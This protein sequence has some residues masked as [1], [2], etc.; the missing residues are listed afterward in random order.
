MNLP[1]TLTRGPCRHTHHP[2]HTMHF[3]SVLQMAAQQRTRVPHAPLCVMHSHTYTHP[4][5]TVLSACVA[6]VSQMAAQQVTRVPP[7][8]SWRTTWACWSA[9]LRHS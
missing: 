7:C 8:L 5:H 6:P 1:P 4:L 3:V 2:H 9:S